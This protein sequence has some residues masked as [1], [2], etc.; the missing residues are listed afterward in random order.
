M[1]L[2]RFRKAKKIVRN[3]FPPSFPLRRES[4]AA[5]RQSRLRSKPAP[6]PSQEGNWAF[7]RRTRARVIP[8]WE[9]QGAGKYMTPFVLFFLLTPTLLF[10]Q[11]DI[12]SHPELTW[13]TIKTDH[14]Q[15][16]FHNGAERTGKVVAKIAEDIYEPITSLYNYKPKGDIHFIIRDHDDYS[17]G[18]AYYFENK[19]EIW[20]T[21]MDFELRGS[22]DWLRN[23]V[24]H[25][26]VH[27]IQLQTANKITR[28]IPVFYFQWIAYEEEAR[29]DVLRGFPNTIISYPIL[30]TS[31]PS[32]FAEGVAQYQV[33]GLGYDNW[34]SHRDM[35]LRSAVLRDSLL[36]FDEMSR[37]GRN[38]IGN[39]MAYNQGF[40]LVSYMAKK[41]GDASLKRASR[42]MRKLTRTSF[43]GAIGA[44][45]G[46]S[47]GS[48]YQEWKA[49]LQKKYAFRTQQ[50]SE[51]LAEGELI[52]KKGIGNFFP[53]AMGENEIAYLA[54]M[55]AEGL[56]RTSLVVRNLEKKK[57]EVIRSRVE[58]PFDWSPEKNQFIYAKKSD[59]SRHGSA[60]FD[61]YT[62]D[63]KSGKEKRLTKDARAHSPAF[64][65]DGENVI[66]VLNGDGTQNIAKLDLA[67]KEIERLTN[68]EHGEQVFHPRWSPDDKTILFSFTKGEGRQIHVFDLETSNISPIV[69]GLG[70]HRNAIFADDGATIYFSSDR[71]GVFNIY[72]KNLETGE[73]AQLTNV[74]GG[75]F[76]P[77]IRNS[78]E[79]IF[80]RYQASG[81]K[82]AQLSQAKPLDK[83]T[84][85]L[86][87]APSL[88]M[89]ENNDGANGN[90]A[91]N[92]DVDK[93]KSPNYDDT[94]LPNYETER[95]K[96]VFSPISF[97]PRVMRD[98]GTTK[99][100]TYF[101]SGEILNNY[102]LFGGLG[103][104]RSRDYDLFLLFDYYKFGPRLFLEA[105]SQVQ[106]T[107]VG[108]DD[109]RYSLG[110][111]DV[112]IEY[113]L[114][115][116]PQHTLRAAFIYSR[117]T[118][119][120]NTIVQRQ[121]LSFGY[122]YHIGKTAQF[123][124]SYNGI[125]GFFA[126]S[127]SPRNGRLVTLEFNRDWN[128]FIRDFEV[129]TNFGTLQ[130]VYDNHY[131]NRFH[132][133][134]RQYL[135]GI[136]LSHSAMLRVR[137]GFI[138]KE[139]DSFY[140]FFGGGLDGMRGYP[141]YSLEGRKLIQST[142]AY[143]VPL[144]KKIGLT[145]GPVQ[146]DK[147]FLGVFADYGDAFDG[148]LDFD[149][150]KR[151]VGTQVRLNAYSF[152]GLPTRI[153]FDA[154]YGMDQFS[155]RQITYG[156]EWRYYFGITFG[157]LD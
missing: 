14:F 3:V 8:S 21:Y 116:R 5:A 55:G 142:V 59:A 63:R 50:I 113:K 100:G 35:L 75:A 73:M 156:K 68:F 30:M 12:N 52:E 67:T 148:K 79:L 86:T 64:S 72:K 110:E 22:H 122:A 74:L 43:G 49:H 13:R 118:A 96:S 90:G 99:L 65:P 61:L 25:E 112:G 62:F 124:Y 120:I 38:S 33:P 106:H 131:F 140:N 141:F 28:K 70:D 94:N 89:A 115:Y 101:N 134:V 39:E 66:F 109:F 126:A 84:R 97:F 36:T 46:Q 145:V 135:P 57:L 146:F 155:N 42:S 47:G 111:I 98:Y 29:P 117:Y 104:N 93:I 107:S 48:L 121:P 31:I 80:S 45:T 24:T 76:M 88:Q 136:S 69:D 23:V 83:N 19:V 60:F 144:L 6:N 125:G 15:I 132:G 102:F 78:G 119:K 133:D 77:T 26:F 51:N 16:H 138:D 32:W 53:L 9:G 4:R 17:N 103:I 41:H 130:E 153:F 27:M 10:A 7:A 44:A 1:I 154:A 20:A 143:R 2:D 92:Y 56:S 91:S 105:Y 58:T 127:A 34:D 54:T 95:Y 150:F 11:L 128:Q 129:N 108:E 152:Y 139:I 82:I 71:T 85:Y 114:P 149:N 37:F 123:R 18:A 40:S 147:L 137:G 151:T 87:Y 157:Y 81:Y